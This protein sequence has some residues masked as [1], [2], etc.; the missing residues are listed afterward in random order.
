M[1]TLTPLLRAR[2]DEGIASL[3][4]PVVN[5]A[6]TRAV[7]PLPPPPE[8]PMPPR[9]R[10]RRGRW[11][12]AF[13]LLFAVGVLHAFVVQVSVVRGHSMEPC[14]H[15]GD[16]LVVDRVGPAL[17]GVS[18]FDVVVLANPRDRSVDYVKR[19]AGLPGDRVALRDGRL[20]IDG[21]PMPESFGPIPD[22]A[23]VLPLTVP[24]GHVFVLGDNRPISCDS[25]EFGLV[26][27][28]LL[29]GTVRARFWPLARLAVF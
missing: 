11:R 12:E 24:A 14:L 5:H 26:P 27:V 18:R 13:A 17:T 21:R 20:W 4:P 25:R 1:K 2:R 8:T 10:R 7:L 16:R 15:D 28:A 23:E 19:I 29:R 3:R 9:A 6:A 22:H